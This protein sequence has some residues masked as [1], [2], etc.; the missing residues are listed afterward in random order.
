MW[1]DAGF[2]Q[3]QRFN[4]QS[5]EGMVGVVLVIPEGVEDSEATE[6]P[7]FD[8]SWMDATADFIVIMGSSLSP[9]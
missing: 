1:K 9:R 3:I 7:F 5:A 8:F 4:G 6:W 2:P